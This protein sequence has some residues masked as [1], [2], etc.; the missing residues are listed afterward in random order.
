MGLGMNFESISVDYGA[1][2]HGDLGL[3][4]RLSL[5]LP[6]P[7]G[8]RHIAQAREQLASAGISRISRS[9]NRTLMMRRLC[10]ISSNNVLLQLI[11][12]DAEVSETRKI[13]GGFL[14]VF[15]K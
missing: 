2:S 14:F 4:H 3:T 7:T 13:T 10:A 9:P 11:D 5:F 8:V 6:V 1:G 15:D 12:G